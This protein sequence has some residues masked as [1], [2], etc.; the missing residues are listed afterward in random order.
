L[1]GLAVDHG[2]YDQAHM[3][4]EIL[5]LSHQSPGR[6]LAQNESRLFYSPRLSPG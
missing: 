4:H 6:L 5:Q 2:Y 3:Q 1:A